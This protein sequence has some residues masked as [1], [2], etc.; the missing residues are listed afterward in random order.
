M[1][2]IKILNKYNIFPAGVWVF[3]LLSFVVGY[4]TGGIVHSAA[5][6]NNANQIRKYVNGKR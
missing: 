6:K 3:L 5:T 4:F 2:I 1:N